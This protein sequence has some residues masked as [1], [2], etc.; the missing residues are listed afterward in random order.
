M[1]EEETYCRLCAEPTPINQLISPD[2]DVAINSKISTKLSWINIDISSKNSLPKT[3][4]FSCFD[5]LERTWSF[6]QNARDAQEKLS[7]IFIKKPSKDNSN[8]TRRS[9]TSNSNTNIPGKPVD[10]DW[11][12]FQ[13]LKVEVK[14]E[15]V[16]TD[17][18]AP[19]CSRKL[20]KSSPLSVKSEDDSDEFNPNNFVSDSDSHDSSDSD[21]PLEVTAKKKK[22]RK[23]TVNEELVMLEDIKSEIPL[24][25]LASNIT[26]ENQPCQCAKCDAQ[27][28]NITILQLHSQQIHDQCCSFKCLECSYV[29]KTFKAFIRHMRTHNNALRHCCEYCNKLFILTSELRQ[30]RSK[31]HSGALKMK[32]K[33]CGLKFDSVEDLK[34][35]K[36]IYGSSGRRN[37]KAKP[38]SELDLKCRDCDKV[39]KS[40]S[41][42]QQHKQVHTARTRNFSCHVCGK[43]FFTKGTL[44]SHI[45]THNDAKPFKCDY[46]PLAFR[47]RGNLMSHISL[48]SGTK[49]FVCEQC[50]KSFRVKR[51]LKSHSIVHTDLMPYTCE[52]CNKSFRFKTRL[53]LHLR[54]HTGAKPYKCVYCHRDF[55]NGSNYKKHMKRRHNIDTS[56]Q[57]FDNIVPDKE[58]PDIKVSIQSTYPE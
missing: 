11:E 7:S 34:A 19:V 47:A 12:E 44:G 37:N 57:K 22:S 2:E 26:W 29:I 17:G 28:E 38:L 5:L 56:K 25:I 50:G 43:M 54:Q 27:C 46:C 48:H 1:A 33:K 14:V 58:E 10:S 55:T 53:N 15:K 21:V 39:F 41:N 31:L 3:I 20:K 6:L 49:P 45:L 32:C 40:K 9:H 52:Y 51:H 8:R 13:E 4:C 36:L 24:E 23:K 42:L 30:H 16:D 35:H 18:N